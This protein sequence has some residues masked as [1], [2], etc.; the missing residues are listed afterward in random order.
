MGVILTSLHGL[1]QWVQVAQSTSHT[2]GHI[3]K[4]QRN[5]VIDFRDMVSDNLTNVRPIFSPPRQGNV[6][7]RL[8][9]E[10]LS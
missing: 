8:P 6:R 1:C 10:R 2:E 7:L 3:E 9:S 5:A 4:A